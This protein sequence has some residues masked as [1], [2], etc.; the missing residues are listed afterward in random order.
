MKIWG[1]EWRECGSGIRFWNSVIASRIGFESCFWITW[2]VMIVCVC[3]FSTIAWQS[4]LQ[5]MARQGMLVTRD[6]VFISWFLS[7]NLQRC[8]RSW[9]GKAWCW[10][11]TVTQNS[12]LYLSSRRVTARGDS[13]KEAIGEINLP[14]LP[15][16]VPLYIN[17]S[18]IRGTPSYKMYPN[19]RVHEDNQHLPS[20]LY[21]T[22]ILISPRFLHDKARNRRVDTCL[23]Y[24]SP[25]P[26]D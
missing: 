20:S 23:L 17:P 26:R 21:T 22:N 24:T 9:R 15:L 4:A 2:E 8:T 19:R 6:R 11:K 13:C 18:L 12:L 1:F 10:L 3:S 5:R 14:F 16:S 25:S 7:I